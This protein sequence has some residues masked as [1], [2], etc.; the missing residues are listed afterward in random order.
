MGQVF[1]AIRPLIQRVGAVVIITNSQRTA[2]EQAARRLG[3]DVSWLLAVI[4]SESG[5]NPQIK[6]PTSSARGLIQ[7]MDSTARD[8][9]FSDSQ[10]LVEA[11]PTFEA[12]VQGPVV[13]YFRA[14][15]P[16]ASKEEF[17]GSVFYP[18]NRHNLDAPLP[19][20]VVAANQS[21]FQTLRDYTD[22]V[23][24]RYTGTKVVEAGAGVGLVA[25]AL[26]GLWWLSKRKGGSRGRI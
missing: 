24:S 9:G 4:Q 3:V 20:S 5:G 12:Q 19:D 15:A 21:K 22:W 26:W 2:A 10:D 8:L 1:Q 18:R 16:F 13:Q 14:Y 6:N 25:F 17:I 23:W 11:Y 7:F